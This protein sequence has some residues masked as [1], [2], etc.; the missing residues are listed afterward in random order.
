MNKSQGQGI[1]SNGTSTWANSSRLTP[2]S[3]FRDSSTRTLAVPSTLVNCCCCPHFY[4]L[5]KLQVNITM[6]FTVN[7][8]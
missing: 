5:G 4:P 1:V 7:P 2:P 8:L 3:T 6:Q